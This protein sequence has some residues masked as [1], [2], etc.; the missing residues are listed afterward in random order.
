MRREG[1]RVIFTQF[2]FPVATA[3][4]LSEETGAK[5]VELD[6]NGGRDTAMQYI[7]LIKYNVLQMS[8]AL[9]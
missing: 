7:E 9:K 4:A 8:T 6:P 3:T 2:M 5:V 1:I